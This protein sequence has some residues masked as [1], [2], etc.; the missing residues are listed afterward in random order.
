MEKI[1]SN[2]EKWL[3]ISSLPRFV[4]K[5]EL[6]IFLGDR[7]INFNNPIYFNNNRYFLPISDVV[8]EMGGSLSFNEGK[9]Y[10]R[11]KEEEVSV[12]LHDGV[13]KAL[14][15]NNVLYISLAD[16][17]MLL[18]L[19]LRWNYK[20]NEIAL[21]FKEDKTLKLS[22]KRSGKPALIRFEDVTAGPPYDDGDNLQKVRIMIDYLH[23]KGMPFHVAWIPRF[24]DPL[25][26]VDN[27]I[28]KIFSMGNADF[29]FTLD[30]ILQRQGIIG[31]HGY[32]HQYGDEVSGDGT[33]FD[34]NRNNNEKSIRNKLENAIDTAQKL[35]IPF[36]FFE[37]PH[38]AATEFQQSIMEQYFDYIYEPCVG[39]WGDKVTVSPRNNRTRYIPTPLGYVEGKFGTTKMVYKIGKLKE[40]I[41][42]SFFYHPSKE[43]N[44]INLNSNDKGYPS[45]I[46][47]TGS[48]LHRIMDALEE[49]NYTPIKIVDIPIL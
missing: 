29:V 25:K 19:R 44:F 14:F 6:N 32:T 34:E 12:N 21:Y 47:D 35:E 13:Y 4:R 36:K 1:L 28:S 27:D 10:I 42:A 22:E 9:L 49:N 5:E 33:E 2:F 39:I 7:R 16:I 37:S 41:I 38:Y 3:M 23:E 30:Y 15:M 45:Y 46:Y 26:G 8:M 20:D 48:P 24:I 11:M 43:M 31:L 17:S 40:G 18:K